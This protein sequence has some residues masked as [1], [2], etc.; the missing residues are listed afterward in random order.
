MITDVIYKEMKK[1]LSSILIILLIGTTFTSANCELSYT[2][3]EIFGH[4]PQ[5]KETAELR[6]L[7]G[8]FDWSAKAKVLNTKLCIQWGIM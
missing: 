8:S 4:L 2:V 6:S 1:F 5:F 7:T 3:F